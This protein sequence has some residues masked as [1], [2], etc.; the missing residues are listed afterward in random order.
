MRKLILLTLVLFSAATANAQSGGAYGITTSVVASGGGAMQGS[1]L[2]VDGTV[3]QPGAGDETAN[4]PYVL[5]SGFWNPLLAPTAATAAIGGRV[6][7]ADNMG[8]KNV[9]IILTGGN[10]TM[11]RLARTSSFGYFTFESVE[12]GHFYI[13]T[14]SSKRY[15]FAQE[16]QSLTLTDDF[17]GV[18]FQANWENRE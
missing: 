18:I 12:V 4:A 7:T 8:V 16:T 2:K 17:T 1:G 11:P 15:G 3:A 13:L 10:L 9:N 5:R 14:V 6:V